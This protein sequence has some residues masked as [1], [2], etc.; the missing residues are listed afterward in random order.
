MFSVDLQAEI[1]NMQFFRCSRLRAIVSTEFCAAYHKDKESCSGC[2]PSEF[3]ESC[4]SIDIIKHL[5][6]NPSVEPFPE[7]KRCHPTRFYYD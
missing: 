4:E 3:Q 5:T 6:E 2:R 1:G 7:E